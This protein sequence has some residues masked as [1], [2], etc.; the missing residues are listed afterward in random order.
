M[1]N[2]DVEKDDSIPIVEGM[3]NSLIGEKSTIDAKKDAEHGAAQTENDKDDAGLPNGMIQVI[4][5]VKS[6]LD[7][8]A[9]DD[10]TSEEAQHAIRKWN[11]GQSGLRGGHF[12]KI[13]M[14]GEH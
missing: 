3:M 4:L 2:E 9:K 7:D 10:E 12:G 1:T 5:G 6:W 11:V 13:L 8:H 14:Q